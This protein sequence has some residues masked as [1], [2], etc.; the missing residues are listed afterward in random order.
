MLR[1]VTSFVVLLALPAL[2]S[3][4]S[5]EGAWR[6]VEIE[7]R[8]GPN[9]GTVSTE[10][11]AT[12]WLFADGYHSLNAT[13]AART[14]PGSSPTDQQLAE[15]FRT[16]AAFAGRYELSGSTLT[17]HL[18]ALLSPNQALTQTREITLTANTLETRATNADGVVVVRR[19]VRAR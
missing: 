11:R 4:Q 19:Y 14:N 3:A 2:A 8:G 17:I 1:A 16:Y 5:I 9:A 13:T 6:Q 7:T 12:Y 18:D 10:S 15:L